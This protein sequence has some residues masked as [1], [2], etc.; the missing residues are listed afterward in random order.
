MHFPH[1]EKIV[2]IDQLSLVKPNRR[3]TP[4][5]RTSMNILHALMVPSPSLVMSLDSGHNDGVQ[6]F[7]N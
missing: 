7:E 6:L 4:S 1:D 5:H 3:I 2:T